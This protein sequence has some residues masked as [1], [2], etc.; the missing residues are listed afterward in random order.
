[1]TD[2]L[3]I[4]KKDGTKTK[5]PITNAF[6]I[7]DIHLGIKM[8]SEEWRENTREYFEKFFIPLI[9]K[10][11]DEGS[12]ILCL[13]DI[14]DDRKS[15]NI[16]V[17]DLAIDIFEKLAKIMPIYI[18]NGNHDMYKKSNNDITSLRSFDNIPNITIFKEPTLWTLGIKGEWNKGCMM[19]PYQGNMERET[20]LVNQN[21]D[22]DYIFMHTDIKNLSY[23][24]G[25]NITMGVD[26]SAVKGV[27][28]SG[29]IHKRQDGG[30]IIY[31]GS[32]YQLRR[33]DIGNH[34]GIYRLWFE[35]GKKDF[36]ENK[37][38]PIFLKVPIEEIRNADDKTIEKII[39]HNY[40]DIVIK[41]NDLRK[42]KLGELYE[43][44]D[45]FNPKRIEIKVLA[46]EYDWG[47]VDEN[48]D[49]YRERS[50]N[51]II[52]S[53]IDEIPEIS[54]EKK[55]KLKDMNL[56]FQKLANAEEE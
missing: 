13:G 28:Y 4:K 37:I 51:E 41:E 24:N 22:S 48:E 6:I 53:L 19:I 10:E 17:N 25:M 31:V 2:R 44:L 39:S 52:E 27:I 55:A 16:A 32:P 3:A 20:T 47:D 43:R 56:V 33:S 5:K 38:S 14:F 42:L 1:M 26:T 7:S 50:I 29:H 12:I 18:I 35:T 49:N 9:E 21:A 30:N 46:N 54:D 36:Y 34:K 8:G 45:I 15:I 40:V 23:D 11:K